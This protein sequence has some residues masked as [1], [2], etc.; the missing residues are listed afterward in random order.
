MPTIYAYTKHQTPHTDICMLLPDSQGA[1][2]ALH[3][4]EL[5][6]VSGI[7]YVCVPDGVQLPEQ[8]PEID[9]QPVNLTPELLASIKAA[10]PH[11]QLINERVVQKIRQRYT[12][13]QEIALLRGQ[14]SDGYK[15]YNTYVEECRAWG[16][17]QKAELG[18]RT[19]ADAKRQAIA[20][21]HREH[22]QIILSL[23]G[24]P[25]EAERGSWPV[26]LQLAKDVLAGRQLD[27]AQKWF[28]AARGITTADQMQAYAAA[29]MKNNAT[30]SSLLGLADK[31]RSNTLARIEAATEE[32]WDKA[33]ADNKA[34]RDQA[35]A[36]VAEML[37]G[38]KA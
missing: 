29:V 31:V 27:D 12:A 4:T 8:P 26:K 16:A 5:A 6:T 30:Y 9:P 25:T 1:D 38:A 35:L 18:L 24:N 23:T 11:V 21:V 32:T 37:K 22:D 17:Q 3:C 36:M 10:S 19:L 13:E 2:D 28:L 15:A 14:P 20:D 7:T 34:E 33:S